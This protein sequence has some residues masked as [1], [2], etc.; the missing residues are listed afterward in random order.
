MSKSNKITLLLF[1]SA[2]LVLPVPLQ[3]MSLAQ[4]QT[5]D[6]VLSMDLTELTTAARNLL[7]KKYPD[8]DWAK[9]AF[10]PFVFRN[11]ST[12]IGYKIAVKE[13]ALLGQ[14]NLK[15]QRAVIPCYCFCEAMNHDN[16][17]YCFLK[18]G[19]LAEGFDAHASGCSICY[20]QAM[21]AF[22]LNDLGATHDEIIAGMEKKYERVIQMKQDGKF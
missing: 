14:A 18:N 3:G 11:T 4:Q 20:G 7:A 12:E 6:Q 19:I 5:F 17:L 9:F 2:L 10:P 8:E 22:L 13:P 1:V 21:L 15:D 16:L